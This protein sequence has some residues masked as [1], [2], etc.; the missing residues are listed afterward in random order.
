MN[1]TTRIAKYA[2]LGMYF[3]AGTAIA[4]GGI[5]MSTLSVVGI[6]SLAKAGRA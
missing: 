6:A 4:V 1:L 5:A 2:E 3:F